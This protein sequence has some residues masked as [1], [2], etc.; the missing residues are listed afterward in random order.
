MQPKPSKGKKAFFYTMLVLLA[1]MMIG[2]IYI[3]ING[4]SDLFG[5]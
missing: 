3:V 1:V 5:S 2:T 4:Y